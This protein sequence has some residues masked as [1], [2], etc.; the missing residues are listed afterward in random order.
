MKPKVTTPTKPDDNEDDDDEGDDE[1]EA[2]DEAEDDGGESAADAEDEAGCEADG[3]EDEDAKRPEEHE[4]GSSWKIQG[5]YSDLSDER[6]PARLG[7]E[8]PEREL[9]N[10]R[11]L[12][13][14]GLRP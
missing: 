2:E 10:S 5:V 11:D 8:I 9:N 1:D 14:I 4:A 12:Q 6:G 7:H 13:P 3:E